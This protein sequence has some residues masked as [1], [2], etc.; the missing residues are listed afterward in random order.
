MLVA[1][2]GPDA[3]G[4]TTL[5]DR[6]AAR[7]P[8]PVLRVSMDDFLVPREARYVRGEL[9]PE[10]Y[11]RDS[12]DLPALV[13][14]RLQPFASGAPVV[15]DRPVPERAVLIVDGVFLHRPELRHRWHLSVHLHVLE[16]E[17]LRRAAVRDRDLM[18]AQ[19]EQRYRSRH[20]PG[21]AL[22]RREADPAGRAD[23]VVDNTD[24]EAPVVLRQG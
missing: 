7:L 15:A 20:L 13:A 14:E 1:V 18:G 12:F 17:T 4:K 3:A 24:P 21:Q 8:G 2:D 5:A 6:L 9:S 11:Y 16:D 10:G 19:V 23:I 22:Y